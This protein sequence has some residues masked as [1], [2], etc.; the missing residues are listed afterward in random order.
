L[1]NDAY[2]KNKFMGMVQNIKNKN[3]V[4][5]IGCLGKI[6]DLQQNADG[7]IIINLT[8]VLRF[9][10]IKEI[11]SDKLYR[12]FEVKYEKFEEDLNFKKNLSMQDLKLDIF[13]KKTIEFF[14][15]NGLLL[16]WNEF[17]KL[18]VHQHINTLAMIAP[19]TNEEKQKI[20]ETITIKDKADILLN[21]ISFYL[22]ETNET[23]NTLQ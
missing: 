8:G 4:Y 21:I 17:K 13:M 5:K 14:E 10:I 9:E 18:D 20:L 23:K 3:E 19:I 2:K 15:K 22:H 16:N 12:E 11:Q 7:R 6:N 1:V